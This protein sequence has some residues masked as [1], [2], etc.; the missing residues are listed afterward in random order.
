MSRFEHAPM[1][2]RMAQMQN[3]T[4]ACPCLEVRFVC[5]TGAYPCLEIRFQL[6]RDVGRYVTRVYVPSALAV[7][8]AWLALWLSVERGV[9]TRVLLGLACSLLPPLLALNASSHIASVSYITVRP[10]FVGPAV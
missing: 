8:G 3:G 2:P 5:G 1:G 10:L 6:R 4:G 7:L 9:G